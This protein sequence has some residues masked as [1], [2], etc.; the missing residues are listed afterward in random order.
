MP[1]GAHHHF[2]LVQEILA[3][4]V[5][6]SFRIR[7]GP[8][9]LMGDTRELCHQGIRSLDMGFHTAFTNPLGGVALVV[10][11][12][13]AFRAVHE[14]DAYAVGIFGRHFA[15]DKSDDRLG[16]QMAD[17]ICPLGAGLCFIADFG[18]GL[19]EEPG[20]AQGMPVAAMS[21]CIHLNVTS[22]QCMLFCSGLALSC[23]SLAL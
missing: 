4:L 14:V 18:L 23:G 21:F 16:P 17:S 12:R 19:G 15:V 5:R 1:D 13:P 2:H 6:G 10:N 8:Y 22:P 20:Q 11:L 7:P 3:W 9:A